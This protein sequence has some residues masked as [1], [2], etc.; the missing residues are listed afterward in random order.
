MT[1]LPLSR[2]QPGTAAATPL[3]WLSCSAFACA[4]EIHL[5]SF[6]LPLLTAVPM[7]MLPT[8]FSCRMV[9]HTVKFIADD[10]TIA[11]VHASMRSF[12]LKAILQ[13]CFWLCLDMLKATTASCYSCSYRKV[14]ANLWLSSDCLR[15]N[16]FALRT[17]VYW[18]GCFARQLYRIASQFCFWTSCNFG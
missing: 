2:L 1:A 4:H 17:L 8:E 7:Q 18:V 16:V 9:L 5:C 15:T 12:V 11:L 6:R 10:L 13:C 14:G 3:V